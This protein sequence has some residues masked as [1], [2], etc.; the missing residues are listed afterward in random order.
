MATQKLSPT[1]W[2]IN[3]TLDLGRDFVFE[4]ARV[5]APVER[6]ELRKF[7]V[8]KRAVR[9]GATRAEPADNVAPGE[10]VYTVSYPELRGFFRFVGPVGYCVRQERERRAEANRKRNAARAERSALRRECAPLARRP[11]SQSSAA[12]L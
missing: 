4:Q 10:M 7:I 8:E 6:E 2:I 12:R 3:I 11:A 5:R 9:I 1:G